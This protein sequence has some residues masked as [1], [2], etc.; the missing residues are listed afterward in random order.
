[1]RWFA[2][3][4]AVTGATSAVQAQLPAASPVLTPEETLLVVS[5]EGQSRRIPDV[6]LF[7]AGVVTQ[8]KT[9]GEAL[10]ANATRMNDVVN[11]LKR[12][13]IADRDIQTSALSLQPQYSNPEQ[14][15]Q[16]RARMTR[17]PYIAPAQPQAP[18]IIGYEARNNVQVRVRKLGEMGR[19]IDTLVQAGAN[20]V[21][22]P[23]F[24][25]DEPKG[26]LDEART[27]AV[28]EARS[29]AELYARA[30]GLRISRILS[31]SEGGGYYPQPIVVTGRMAGAPP[32]PPPPPSPVAPGELMLGATVSIQFAL[33]P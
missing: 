10:G 31:I 7:S 32:A 3:L 9:G 20:Q 16:I 17:E 23:S 26:A 13:G 15:A 18:R 33:R 19:I 22:G 30:A 8:G 25:L 24:T 12:A 29:R 14:E 4:V 1:M 21:D 28:R 5:G 11:A 27:E 2:F 6:A